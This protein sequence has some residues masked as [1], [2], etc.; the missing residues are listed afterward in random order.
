MDYNLILELSN[1]K[2]LFKSY[3]KDVLMKQMFHLCW[4][5][6]RQKNRNYRIRNN[7]QEINEITEKGLDN[8]VLQLT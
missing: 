4:Q 2:T 1:D 7:T 6:K 5:V 3:V 8:L